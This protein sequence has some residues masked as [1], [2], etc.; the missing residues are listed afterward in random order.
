MLNDL[1]FNLPLNN[2]VV[3]NIFDTHSICF[4]NINSLKILYLNARSLKNK[5]E[6]ITYILDTFNSVIHLVIIA[7]TWILDLEDKNNIQIK[8]YDRVL[9]CRKTRRGGGCAI[10]VHKNIKFST[11]DIYCDEYNHILSISLQFDKKKF[12]VTAIYRPPEN[13]STHIETF[14]KKL[15]DH[16]VSLKSVKSF[17]VGDFNFDINS[18]N[19][20]NIET[21]KTIINSNSFFFCH[22]EITRPDSNSCLDHVLTNSLNTELYIS[23]FHHDISDHL[24]LL[25]EL[26]NIKIKK[27][28]KSA[29]R[30][31]KKFNNENIKGKLNSL[32]IKTSDVGETVNKL[33]S[34]ITNVIKSETVVKL[35][36]D[37]RKNYSAPWID[38]ECR[39]IIEIKNY[40]FKKYAKNKNSEYIKNKYSYWSN[41][42]TAMKRKKKAEYD[43]KQFTKAG[44]DLRKTWLYIKEILT[45]NVCNKDNNGS[46]L[47]NTVSSNKEKIEKLD[48]F[49]QFYS[50]V[51]EIM[52][53]K[54]KNSIYYPKIMTT[55][56][57]KFQ[58]IDNNKCIKLIQGLSNSNSAGSDHISPKIIKHCKL[59]L[60]QTITNLINQ[61]LTQ[62]EMP[63]S[64]KTSRIVPIAKGSGDENDMNNFRPIAIASV[65]SKL[66]ETYINNQLTEFLHNEKLMND[67]Q[68]GFKKNS[69][70]EAALF[71]VVSHIQQGIE[72]TK[73]VVVVFFDLTKAFDS[74]DRGIL[75]R[76]LF[77]YGVKAKE[78]KWFASYLKDRMQFAECQGIKSNTENI[79]YG[80][81]QGSNLG[82]TL[83]TCY[84]N[85]LLN[86]KLNG[87][88][89]MF[90]DDLA[91]IYI[92][93]YCH[94]LQRS[95][96]SDMTAI[97]KW[98]ETHKLTINTDK[99]KYLFFNKKNCDNVT[100]RYN[101][102]E[103]DRVPQYKYLG[104]TIDDKLNWG[105]HINDQLKKARRI[106]GIFK[107]INRRV[108]FELKRS[109]Y[110]AMFHS[111][112]TYA[113]QIWGNSYKK[114]IQLL[115]IAQ[116]KAIKNL[117]GYKLRTPTLDIYRNNNILMLNYQVDIKLTT[118]VHQML[119][120]KIN[121]NVLL[122]F[123]NNYHTYNTRSA[124]NIRITST[125]KRF[126]GH[127]S[128]YNLAYK[129]YNELPNYIKKINELYKFKKYLNEFYKAHIMYN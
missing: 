23:L 74:I 117:F 77:E 2:H 96:N 17:I 45:G 7:E 108:P 124:D 65:F 116:N 56:E 11:Q 101:N 90:A 80:V 76:T 128:I 73:K 68:Y 129:K 95:L 114:N 93:E 66:I 29:D 36:K 125:R 88:A 119:K 16:L 91:I 44:K 58:I 49:N 92:E 19:D 35:V 84:V 102:S 112:I 55:K 20:R 4:K 62:G 10:F 61:S 54:F 57:F 64:L 38:N 60:A 89:F 21:Y 70:T 25:I 69:S 40:W 37:N 105:A 126:N 100:V 75:L 52:A 31:S 12:N 24:G 78:Y 110:Y 13:L 33:S 63:K 98:M 41:K 86:L 51:G 81:I 46:L 85:S 53:T 42:T 6:D 120:N 14:L 121:T 115:Q 123:N 5:I 97:N 28:I 94:D 122:T 71:D 67:Q 72:K 107:A 103:L 99:S 87:K 9:S 27:Q 43:G 50:S 26:N 59:E 22:K 106:A 15:E 8:N 1:T 18:T 47:N 3:T 109:L 82:P 104:V 83:F 113:I 32:N 39:K 48:K 34:I 118:H 127:D 79:K 30:M 111:T